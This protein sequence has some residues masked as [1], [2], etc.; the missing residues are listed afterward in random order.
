MD[1]T[2][3]WRTIGATL[4]RL[5]QFDT[6]PAMVSLIESFKSMVGKW[7]NRASN[8]RERSHVF[9][10][11][12]GWVELVERVESRVAVASVLLPVY[13]VCHRLAHLQS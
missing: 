7:W 12:Q 6:R 10:A 4:D 2:S 11:V 13:L 1:V 9:Y 8:S 5:G 3:L